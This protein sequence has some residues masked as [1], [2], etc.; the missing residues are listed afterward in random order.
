MSTEEKPKRAS[1]NTD[2]KK[3]QAINEEMREHRKK[4]AIVSDGKGGVK[5]I[6]R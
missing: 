3:V 2:A 4:F 6:E 1:K 5:Q